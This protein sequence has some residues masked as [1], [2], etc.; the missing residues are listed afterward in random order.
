M[1]SLKE[2]YQAQ[3]ESLKKDS[4]FKKYLTPLNI[5]ILVS[6]IVVILILVIAIPRL[7]PKSPE[8][9]YALDRTLIRE[10]A[11]MYATGFAPAEFDILFG[12]NRPAPPYGNYP[13]YAALRIGSNSSVKEKDVGNNELVPLSMESHPGGG[14]L[15]GGIPTWEDIDGDGVRNTNDEKLFYHKASPSPSVDHWNT[16]SM[17]HD[18]V[19]YVVDSRNWFI[20]I[21]LLIEKQYLKEIPNSASPD[22]SKN[23]TG[24]YSYYINKDLE[25]SSVLYSRPTV[26]TD[27]FQ[28]V[29]P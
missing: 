24:S 22:N 9:M 4:K 1:G 23:G 21:D 2:Q 10:A 14:R 12:A 25:I 26:D 27:G 29:Y 5:G 20:N 15:Q 6:G 18:E 11:L 28:N 16:S 3:Q 17:S 13:T 8:E 7:I 19:D